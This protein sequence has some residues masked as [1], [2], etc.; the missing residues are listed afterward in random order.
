MPRGRGM[1]R[2]RTCAGCWKDVV[3]LSLSSIAEPRARLCAPALPPTSSSHPPTQLQIAHADERRPETD[4][5]GA[6]RSRQTQRR[7]CRASRRCSRGTPPAHPARDGADTQPLLG[8][9][10]SGGPS[11][12][13]PAAGPRARACARDAAANRSVPALAPASR[14]ALPRPPAPLLARQPALEPLAPPRSRAASRRWTTSATSTRM[15]RPSCPRSA[16]SSTSRC[17][18]AV[19]SPPPRRAHAAPPA[20]PRRLGCAW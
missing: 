12:A 9:C 1:P 11:D 6:K 4:D 17:V 20:P 18:R 3:Q 14:A 13:L 5:A 16:A 2:G 10:P 19:R 15:R 7:R 8:E